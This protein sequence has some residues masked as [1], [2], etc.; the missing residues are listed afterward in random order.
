MPHT[1]NLPPTPERLQQLGQ[2]WVGGEPAAE[3]RSRGQ[4]CSSQAPGHGGDVT[5][6]LVRASQTDEG[7]IET[8]P[9]GTSVSVRKGVSSAEHD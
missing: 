4:G 8:S 7:E 5:P 1:K 6:A 2:P 9:L 3:S